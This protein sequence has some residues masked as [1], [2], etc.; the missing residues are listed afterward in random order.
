VVRIRPSGH[1]R[2]R[3]RGADPTDEPESTSSF[4]PPLRLSLR[5]GGQPQP[6]HGDGKGR[7]GP[8][9]ASP[10][11]WLGTVPEEGR[12]STGEERGTH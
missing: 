6:I 5:L 11:W 1:R 2:V 4:A 10:G 12:V 7:L 3:A 9:Q 8:K